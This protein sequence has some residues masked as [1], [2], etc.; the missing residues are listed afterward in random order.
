MKILFAVCIV[1]SCH[2]KALQVYCNRV[3]VGQ[4]QEN[5]KMSLK[6]VKRGRAHKFVTV[7]RIGAIYKGLST[8]RVIYKRDCC[9]ITQT[10]EWKRD[11]KPEVRRN[12]RR[13]S[14]EE[15]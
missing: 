6:F 12:L 15:S 10:R 14:D 4:P 5:T 8:S 3:I 1:R 13:K 9:Y 2:P 7:R 11:G